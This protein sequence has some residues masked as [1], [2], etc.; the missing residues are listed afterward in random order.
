MDLDAQNTFSAL[1]TGDVLSAATVTV[2]LPSTNVIDQGPAGLLVFRGEG[3]AH[4]AP[5]LLV[6]MAAAFTGAGDTIQAVLQDSADG[7]S[8][9]DV[10]VGTVLTPAQAQQYMYLAAFRIPQRLRRY[11]RVVYR[12]TGSSQPGGTVIAFLALVLDQ[13]DIALR[14]APPVAFVQAGQVSEAVGNGILAS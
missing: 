6:Q 12:T 11:L 5:Y 2:D 7:N 9:A 1:S 8:F 14:S 10:A 13:V 4:I 3:G